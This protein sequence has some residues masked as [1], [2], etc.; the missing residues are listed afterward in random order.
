MRDRKKDRVFRY[1]GNFFVLRT[2]QKPGLAKLQIKYS[3][4]IKEGF[5]KFL[6]YVKMT[7]VNLTSSIQFIVY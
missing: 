2:Y 1:E 4:A 6:D 3:H 5:V 7:P